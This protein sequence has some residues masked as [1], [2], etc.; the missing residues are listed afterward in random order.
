M[1]NKNEKDYAILAALEAEFRNEYW[2]IRNAR[3]TNWKAVNRTRV[4]AEFMYIL[5]VPRWAVKEA[6]YCLRMVVCERCYS[7][8]LRC[9]SITG[10]ARRGDFEEG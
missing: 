10:R 7:D 5:G 1:V 9:H 4:L 6:R 3:G 8:E 2:K